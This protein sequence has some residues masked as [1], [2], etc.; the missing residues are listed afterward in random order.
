[1][2]KLERNERK[3]FERKAQ[4]LLRYINKTGEL[5]ELDELSKRYLYF[6]VEEQ[7]VDGIVAQKMVSGRIVFELSSGRITLTKKGLNFC[8]KPIPWEAGANIVLA[9]LTAASVV[10]AIVQTL[11]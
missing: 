6:C 5:P 3:R 2:F 11:R 7:Y 10:V 1:M 9:V 8:W 4:K